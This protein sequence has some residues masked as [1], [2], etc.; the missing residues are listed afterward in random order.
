MTNHPAVVI[1]LKEAGRGWIEHRTQRLAAA[2]AFYTML[3]L[4]PLAII[5]ISV[6]GYFLG[7]D[8]ARAGIVAQIEH[9]VSKNAALGIEGLIDKASEPEQS[10]TT[11]AISIGL[12]LFSATAVFVELKDS[13]DTV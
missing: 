5:A 10:R 2:L 8:A 6:A 1:L 9:L 7:E 13:L 3:A 11:A 4:A 12:L